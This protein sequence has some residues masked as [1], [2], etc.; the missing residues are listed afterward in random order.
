MIVF[1]VDSSNIIGSGH[2]MRCIALAEKLVK[3]DDII[4][5][6]RKLPNNI[7][8]VIRQYGFTVV[9]LP[10][11]G[12]YINWLGVSIYIDIDDCVRT[13]KGIGE[14]N[15]LIVDNYHLDK[16][17]ELEIK[18]FVKKLMVIDDLGNRPHVCDILL[19]TSDDANDFKY[20]TLINEECRC[21]FGRAFQVFRD[22]F[23]NIRKRLKVRKAEVNSV[24]ISF[25][26]SDPTKETNKL[27]DIISL[28]DYD[29]IY[30][31]IVVGACNSDFSTIKSRVVNK[32]NIE[33]LFQ[34]SNM[35]EILN[36]VDFCIGAAGVSNWERVFL[37]VPSFSVSV[38]DNQK[39]K[40]KT[41][42]L[43]KPYI[44]IGESFEQ[45]SNTYKRVID[46]AINN[47]KELVALHYRAMKVYMN[48]FFNINSL[49]KEIVGD[50]DENI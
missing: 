5:I 50:K 40:L 10:F 29:E 8:N 31:Y 13:L 44:Y 6:C 23:Y 37:G 17:W 24:L 28:P 39:S 36:K 21:F 20:K 22:E 43:T 27:L 45:D 1:R 12:E 4:F 7:N 47:P 38:A 33:V 46:W 42:D 9:E 19:D 15:C 18:K 48:N 2:V 35:A 16:I 30:F 14:V 41:F 49:I 25:G 26:G 3:L 11:E 32:K 34:I